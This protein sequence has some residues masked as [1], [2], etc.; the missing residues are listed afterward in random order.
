[1][2]NSTVKTITKK[3]MDESGIVQHKVIVTTSKKKD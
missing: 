2:K 3:I 1:M